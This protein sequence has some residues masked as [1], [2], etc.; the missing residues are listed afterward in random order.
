MMPD[1]IYIHRTIHLGLLSASEIDITGQDEQ[2]IRKDA[3]LEWA[4]A[5]KEEA[6]AS[7]RG[8]TDN[9]SWGESVAMRALIDKIESL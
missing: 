3:L 4:K 5:Y 9:P 8:R 2:Y 1:K 6:D 7:A